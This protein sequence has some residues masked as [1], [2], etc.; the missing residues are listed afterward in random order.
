MRKN[1]TKNRKVEE[2]RSSNLTQKKQKIF[3]SR[4]SQKDKKKASKMEDNQASKRKVIIKDNYLV[5]DRCLPF[6]FSLII[7]FI[8]G[9]YRVFNRVFHSM[10]KLNCN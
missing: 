8:L 3:T 9:R 4:H 1:I 2:N 7:E 5:G 10:C 6:G